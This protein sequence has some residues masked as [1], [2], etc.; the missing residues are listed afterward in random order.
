MKKTYKAPISKVIEI[1]INHGIL[2][3]SNYYTNGAKE[4]DSGSLGSRGSRYS[5]WEDDSEDFNAE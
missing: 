1:K 2:A 3:V 5:E 4:K